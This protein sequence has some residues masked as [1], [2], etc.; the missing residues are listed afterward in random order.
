MKSSCSTVEKFPRFLVQSCSFCTHFS[1]LNRV[2]TEFDGDY[3]YDKEK[4]NE[5]NVNEND[6][7]L[8]RIP[9]KES[10]K[11]EEEEEDVP[12]MNTNINNTTNSGVIEMGD[13]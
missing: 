3:Y 6:N 5:I 12:L 4:E 7:N 2:F 1:L 9:S 11:E 13:K 8:H 10:K